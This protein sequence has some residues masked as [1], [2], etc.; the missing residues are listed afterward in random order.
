M[1]QSPSHSPTPSKRL[2][3]LCESQRTWASASHRIASAPPQS[4]QS[5][6]SVVWTTV[7]LSHILIAIWTLRWLVFPRGED[8]EADMLQ[9]R[10]V[11]SISIHDIGYWLGRD[12]FPGRYLDILTSAAGQGSAWTCRG[13]NIDVCL[14][15]YAVLEEE[16]AARLRML[17]DAFVGLT[18]LWIVSMRRLW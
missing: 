14:Y 11:S 13:G 3:A 12:I 15:Y 18:G 16:V 2:F 5:G 10:L 8:A 7:Y 1:N 9:N 17:T 6:V 4:A